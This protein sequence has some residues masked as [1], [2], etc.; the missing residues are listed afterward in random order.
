MSRGVKAIRLYVVKDDAED[1]DMLL[2]HSLL[3]PFDYKFV[4]AVCDDNE[5]RD[6]RMMYHKLCVDEIEYEV[7]T[8]INDLYDVAYDLYIVD[9]TN[10]VFMT[11]MIFVVETEEGEYVEL[12]IADINNWMLEEFVEEAWVED[13]DYEPDYEDSQE[14]I[15]EIR[16][17]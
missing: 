1:V 7:V 4:K 6:V 16:V 3:S 12:S 9:A 5:F 15:V 2:F 17:V 8:H 13:D 11:G 10:R 14:D